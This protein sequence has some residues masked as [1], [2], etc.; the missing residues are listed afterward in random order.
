V[1][2]LARDE[3]AELIASGEDSFV[4]FK[5]VRTTPKDVAKELCAFINANGGRLLIG[6]D[7]EDGA[8]HDAGDWD[9]ERVMNVARTLID[10]PVIPTY[11]R[12]R[13]DDETMIAIVSVDQG[14]EKPY[15]VSQ[16]E[17][18]RY[19]IRVG[20]T[21]REASREELIRLTQASGAVVSDSRPVMGTSVDDLKLDLLA[22]RFAGRRTINFPELD[23]D[24]RRRLLIDAE[25]L[26]AE[27]GAATIGGLLSYGTDPQARLPFAHVSCVAYPATSPSREISDR[28]TVGGRIDQ[29]IEGAADFV[30]RNLANASSL[31]GL[32]R[33]DAARPS[34]VSLREVIANAVAHRHYGIEGP[35][36]VQ[37]F[38]DRIDVR[39]PG[40]PPNGV[41]PEGMRIG[42]SVRRNQFLVQ[43]LIEKRLVD[44]LGRGI[45]LLYEEA[46]ELGL[47][48]PLITAADHWTTVTLSLEPA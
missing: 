39:S 31:S 35:I 4:E 42:V 16:G 34:T 7:D 17:S 47:R 38:T 23:D 1:G 25:I 30:A 41:T 28:A 21:S 45:V 43:H 12:L 36:G 46:A 20:S 18:R 24:E 26:H 5:D 11:Q 44:A 27:G 9:E 37:V 10:P 33:V 15:A 22:D 13:W 29:Q 48:A 19:Y 14:V 2:P 8:L 3:F 40:E 6:V 32:Q